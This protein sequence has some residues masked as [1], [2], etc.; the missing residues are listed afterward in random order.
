MGGG[1]RESLLKDLYYCC[2]ILIQWKW[3][4]TYGASRNLTSDFIFKD[5]KNGG[6]FGVYTVDLVTFIYSITLLIN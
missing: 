4:P 1:G 2:I 6:I 5:V 3:L